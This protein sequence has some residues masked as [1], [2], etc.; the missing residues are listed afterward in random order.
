[1]VFTSAIFL[2]VFLPLTIGIYFISNNHFKNIWLLTV[3]LLFYSWGE[4]IHILLM[5]FSIIINYILAILI[6]KCTSASHIL[7]SRILLT[8]TI[9]TDL[10]LLFYYK[11]WTFLLI[12]VN[13]LFSTQFHVPSIALPIGISF[14]TFQALSYVVDVYRG[15]ATVQKNPLN[16]GLYI[17]LFPQLIAGPI[18]RYVDIEKQLHDRITSL[19][20]LYDGVKLFMAG[21]SKKVL[22]ADQLAPL[23][24]T[25]FASNGFSAPVAWIG[26]I[27][28]SLQ[29]FF[30][31][32]GY[33]DMAV[34]LGKIFGFEFVNNFN[35]PYISKTI[36]E[37]WHRWHIS[38]SSWFRDYVYIPL[39]GSRC[40]PLRTYFNL[41]L[42]FFLTGLWH[43]AS[44]NYIVWG[45]YYAVF[46]ILERL[47]GNCLLKKIPQPLQHFYALIVI[48][49]GWV[50]FRADN[51]PNACMYINNLFTINNHSFVD[52][53]SIVNRK[54][55]FCI[56]VGI[57]FSI[58]WTNKS[59][60]KSH[61]FYDIVIILIFIISIAYMLGNGFS[62]FLYFRF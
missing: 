47:F 30:D 21:F 31:F 55:I 60:L 23:V 51:L 19:V 46:L 5:I 1:M 37:F 59:K 62:P 27:S 15:N 58:P 49:L 10:S 61:F 26:A 52:L 14:F 45:L 53:L 56:L 43:G 6:N 50:L 7:L 24:D 38:L 17:A 18:V 25:V 34:G 29:I 40:K 57:I 36:K 54:H 4:P 9:I 41:G 48:L 39:G 44:W 33:S 28:Y 16:L 22:I 13:H 11:Y 2:F 12:N 35:F 42:V 3:S 20:Q 8:F 32:S